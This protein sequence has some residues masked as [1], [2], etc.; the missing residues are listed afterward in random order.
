MR[1]RG[2]FVAL[3]HLLPLADYNKQYQQQEHH[4]GGH[5]TYHAAANDISRPQRPPIDNRDQVLIEIHHV[6]T[7]SCLSAHH[8]VGEV[9][10][11]E[12]PG[13]V[14]PARHHESAH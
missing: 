10:L 7:I 11:H 1:L 12:S 13:Q 6:W 8:G 14:P 9:G 2:S 3:P 5:K 4:E